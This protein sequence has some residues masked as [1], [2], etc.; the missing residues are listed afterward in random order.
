MQ[1][2]LNVRSVEDVSKDESQFPRFDADLASELRASLDRFLDD[3]VWS[4][5]SDYRQLFLADAYFTSARIAHYYGD[6]WK[7][8]DDQSTGLSRIRVDD[9]RIGLLGHPWLLSSLAYRDSTSPIHRGVFLL[10]HVLGRTLRPPN[11]AFI[12][13]S[14]DLHPDLTTR[15]RVALQTGSEACQVCHRQINGLGFVLESFDAVGR[16]REDDRG[17]KIDTSGLYVDRS[18]EEIR[19]E[20]IKALA[21]YLAT[22]DDSHRGFV[23]RAFRHFVKQPPAAWG[24]E[25]LD[26]L[27]NQFQDNS[28]SIRLLLIE[29][30]ATAAT[31]PIGVSQ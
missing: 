13:L 19:F 4:D 11:E 20:S 8:D 16:P 12:P 22:S 31:H 7:P 30:A 2:W 23:D 21:E 26:R 25:T 17:R 5:V 14:P 29:I 6:A 15:E 9:G 3:V 1:E 10:R 24:P 27:T 18:G 28:C